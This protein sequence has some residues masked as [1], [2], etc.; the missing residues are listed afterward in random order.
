M[1]IS[2]QR[3]KELRERTGVSFMQC[4]KALD[5]AG[6]DLDKALEVLARLS[7]DLAKKKFDRT[8]GSGVVQS[9]IHGTKEVGAMVMLSCETDFVAKNEEFVRLAY[10]IAMH[11]AATRPLYVSREEVPAE[12]VAR[13]RAG[14]AEEAKDKPEGVREN[15]IEGKLSAKLREVVLLEQPF[16]KDDTKTIKGLLD[17][18][19]QKFGE[20]T[21]VSKLA[22]F[23][24]R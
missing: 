18:A 19:V 14:F 6:G 16:I 10:D 22:V 1:D 7:G 11:A 2:P 9:Y 17:G 23:S 8:L 24:F 13:L 15:I 20:R 12:D 4:K 5:E 3:I 21:E